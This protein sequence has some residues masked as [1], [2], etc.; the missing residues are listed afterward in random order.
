M[1]DILNAAVDVIWIVFSY[2]GSSQNNTLFSH[3]TQNKK[4]LQGWLTTTKKN[5]K[6]PLHNLYIKSRSGEGHVFPTNE[7]RLRTKTST[8]KQTKAEGHGGE[9]FGGS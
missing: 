4:A 3:L 1:R 7:V 8:S 2:V 5:K 9:K 6:K